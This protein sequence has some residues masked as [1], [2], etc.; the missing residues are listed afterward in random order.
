MTVNPGFGGQSF[1]ESMLPKIAQARRMA[2]D[3]GSWIDIAVDGGIDVGTAPRVVCAGANLLVA[4]TSLFGNSLPA[5][6]ACAE[7]QFAAQ[8]ALEIRRV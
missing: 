2:D 5:K 8:S 3:T 6:Q 4:G 7:L 1:I